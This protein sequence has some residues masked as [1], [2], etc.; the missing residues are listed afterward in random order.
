MSA[1]NENS[2]GEV[3][4]APTGIEGFDVMSRGGLPRGS[5]TLV[6][7]GSGSGKTVFGLQTLVN[8]A[9]LYDEPG[10]F[11]SFEE[12]SRKLL[13]NA[14]SFGWSLDE[15]KDRKLFFLD[16]RPID[17]SVTIGEFDLS[18]MLAMLS[19]KV[20][21]MKVRRIVFDSLDVLLCLLPGVLERRRE[22]NR[23]HA[24]LLAHELTAVI[25]AKL[26]RLENPM[27][28]DDGSLQYLPFIVDCVVTLTHGVESGF[29]QRRVRVVKYRGSSFSESETPFTIGPRGLA[30]AISDRP[31][32]SLP[33]STDKIS[34]GILQLDEMLYGGLIRGSTTMITGNPGTAKT[35][36][37][38]AFAEAAAKRGERMVYVAFDETSEEIVRNLSSVNIHLQEHVDSGLLRMY[39]EYVGSNCAEEHF[40]NI[41][42]L[43]DSQRAS[44]LVID[45]FTAFSNSGD[46]KSTQ[47]V[48]ARLVRWVKSEGITLVCTSLPVQGESGFSG[49]NL[50]I[51]TVADTW[52]Y[53]NFF[54]GGER[55]RGLTIIKSRGTNHSNQVRELILASSG[56]SIAPPYTADGTV[57]MGTMRW[58]KERAESEARE[59][60]KAEYERH[61]AA[62]VEELAEMNARVQTLQRKIVTKQLAKDSMKSQEWNRKADETSRQSEMIRLR[63]ADELGTSEATRLAPTRK[64]AD[65]ESRP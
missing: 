57:L 38:G 20:Q 59:R 28:L 33:L 53:L 3:S 41:R 27:P 39:N 7:G 58:Q 64:P 63:Q 48:A 44:C 9:R 51:T 60:L 26:D 61:D 24:W 13:V 1:F 21:A 10:L 55:N 52:I 4:K 30:I 62:I 17:G 18:G 6:T 23:L 36:L 29:S 47:A 14:A 50:K 15:L 31:M 54:D 46:L 65:D 32:K 19:A 22:I 49:T 40:Q 35:T 12:D 56:L 8:G 42:K 11:I 16:A 37:A 5:V 25:T 45:P 43:V 34:F 2:R